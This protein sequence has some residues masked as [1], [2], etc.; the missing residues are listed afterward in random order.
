[1]L[2]S[3]LF[4][5]LMLNSCRNLMPCWWQHGVFLMYRRSIGKKW[6]VAVT[7]KVPSICYQFF[8]QKGFMKV[9]SFY[10]KVI[11]EKNIL[12]KFTTRSFSMSYYFVAAWIL[13]WNVNYSSSSNPEASEFLKLS[14]SAPFLFL[15]EKRHSEYFNPSYLWMSNPLIFH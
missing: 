2:N 9:I 7:V 5:V 3:Q 13:H 11:Y 1:M 15:T 4:I 10:S 14:Y 8:F 6:P 12:L